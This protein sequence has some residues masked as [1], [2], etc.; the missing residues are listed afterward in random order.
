MLRRKIFAELRLIL[1][2][3]ASVTAQTTA[4]GKTTHRAENSVVASNSHLAFHSSYIPHFCFTVSHWE[5][6]PKLQ[7]S[8][9]YII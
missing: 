5:C 2:S 8:L 9:E 1:L 6:F 4:E 3:R 7:R